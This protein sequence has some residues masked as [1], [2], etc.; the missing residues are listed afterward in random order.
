MSMMGGGQILSQLLPLSLRGCLSAPGTEV[1]KPVALL[2][3][4][5]VL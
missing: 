2:A 5:N 1:Q 3:G 4:T